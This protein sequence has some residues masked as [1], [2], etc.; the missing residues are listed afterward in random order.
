VSTDLPNWVYNVVNELVEQ[1]D[2]HPQLLFR[3][4]G[5]PEPVKYDWCPCSA[6]AKVPDEVV[7]HARVL[8]RYL[9]QTPRED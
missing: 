5:H 4:S 2:E 8:N 7:A 6:L 9:A 3:A 1:R